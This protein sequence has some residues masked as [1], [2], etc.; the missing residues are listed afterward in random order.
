MLLSPALDN[1]RATFLKREISALR[2]ARD[3]ERD[4]LY[5]VDSLGIK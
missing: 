3:L 2:G 1:A 4:K 5:V